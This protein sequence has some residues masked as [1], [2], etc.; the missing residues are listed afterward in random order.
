[1]S[2]PLPIHHPSIGSTATDWIADRSPR[3]LLP[4]VE[5]L[6]QT[7]APVPTIHIGNGTQFFRADSTSALPSL[8]ANPLI[9]NHTDREFQGNLLLHEVGA[10]FILLLR[11]VGALFISDLRA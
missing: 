7:M 11:E 8:R 9:H 6:A 4:F 1:M 2:N 3:T 5:V 10:L